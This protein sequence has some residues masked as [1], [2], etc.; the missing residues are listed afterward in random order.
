MGVDKFRNCKGKRIFIV[1][2]DA[3]FCLGY[4]DESGEIVGFDIDLVKRS[5]VYIL[6]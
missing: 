6:V 5:K 4:R 2:L 3:T 1:G